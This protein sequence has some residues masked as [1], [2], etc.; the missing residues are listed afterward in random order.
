MS[1]PTFQLFPP[2]QEETKAPPPKAAPPSPTFQLFPPKS[3]RASTPT[4]KAKAKFTKGGPP[5]I[6]NWKVAGDGGIAGR[7]TGSDAFRDGEKVSTSPIATKGA[8]KE[9]MTVTTTSGSKY[10]LGTEAAAAVEGGGFG[11]FFGG[12]GG[13]EV[14][15]KREINSKNDDAARLREEKRV[16]AALAAEERRAEAKR[17]K[18]EAELRRREAASK[19]EADAEKRRAQAAAA[20]AA[21]AEKAAAENAKKAAASSKREADAEKRR[22]QASAAAAAKAE[23]AAAAKASKTKA[24]KKA[25]EPKSSPTISLFGGGGRAAPAKAAAA[26]PV[27]VKGGAIGIINGW[28]LANDGG[29]TG[30][31]TGSSQ[32]RDNEKVATSPLVTKGALREGQ[33]V[34]TGSGSKYQLGSP[35]SEGGGVGGGG[36]GGLFGAFG[37]GGGGGAVQEKKVEKKAVAVKSRPTPKQE[38]KAVSK[39]GNEGSSNAFDIFSG[40]FDNQALPDREAP[41]KPAVKKQAPPKQKKAPP[42]TPILVNWRANGDGSISGQIID[43]PNFMNGEAITT[44][45]IVK[46]TVESG[47]IVQTGSGSR[48]ALD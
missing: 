1:S 32:F 10:R 29:V 42:G 4:P 39:K 5:T 9:G 37:G 19:K 45:P 41:K 27:K 28:K 13:G 38:K 22:A 23:K 3:E 36:G 16:S 11:G 24:V 21:K 7:I 8:F 20:A 48:Y 2:K 33:V 46:G 18:E 31:I 30:R 47:E 15:K 44:S 6:N 26:A 17:K 14:E 43:S 12:G 40:A 35:A 25:P 34:Q